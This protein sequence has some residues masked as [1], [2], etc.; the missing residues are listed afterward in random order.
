MKLILFLHELALGG[1]S[2]NAI[3][4]AVSL[5]DTLNYEIV[6]FAPPGPMLPKVEAAGLRYVAAPEARMHPSVPRIR[7]LRALVRCERPD[8]VYV[9]E[10]W[11]LL[12][13]FYGV[14][15]SM[16]VPILLT[17]M[18]MFVVRLLPRSVP[19]TF[20]TMELVE[21][22]R[23]AGIREVG[24][25]VPSVDLESNRIESHDVSSVR[26]SLGI[27]PDEILLVVVSRLA[28]IM[29]AESLRLAIDAAETM[30]RHSPIRLLIVGD[31]PARPELEARAARVNQ[32][33][34]REAVLLSGA[35]LD[36]R[37]AYAAADIV[38]GMGSSA[39]RGMAY[40]KPV[41]IVGEA[42]FAKTLTPESTDYF[43][44]HGFFGTGRGDVDAEC[45]SDE[46]VPLIGS[47]TLRQALGAYSVQY[48]QQYYSLDVVSAQLGEMCEDA[49]R[50][51]PTMMARFWD[52]MRTGSIYLRERRF[53]WRAPARPV[54]PL[55][56]SSAIASNE[57]VGSV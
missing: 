18:Q 46:L 35:W 47:A 28:H 36:P 20:G 56:L 51:R 32:K 15:L 14:H 38:I 27:H 22:A 5:R 6:L 29:K 21:I 2:V 3:E 42:G 40:G 12:D 57:R 23:R 52:S 41:V 8:L 33:L 37:P 1:T 10:T 43:H 44:Y 25:L 31:G 39:L 11:A 19:T 54:T 13:A 50:F 17:D 48:V 9:W 49:V 30:G 34:N 24:L 26:R 7:A 45:L 53:L 55:V 4:L 16:R